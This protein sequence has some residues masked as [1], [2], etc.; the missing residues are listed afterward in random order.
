MV[1]VSTPW[2]LPLALDEVSGPLFAL[3]QEP[4][5]VGQE[6]PEGKLWAPDAPPCPTSAPT[7]SAQGKRLSTPAKRGGPP[8]PSCSGA[9]GAAVGARWRWTPPSLFSHQSPCTLQTP[10]PA[11]APSPETR[12]IQCWRGPY[13]PVGQP[14]VRET[15][16]AL[17]LDRA[18]LE[19]Q[20]CHFWAG[21]PC[22]SP[23]SSLR[24]FTK[25]MGTIIPYIV[26]G[27]SSDE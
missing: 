16:W 4:V 17:E 24:S 7:V 10:A 19:P 18:G 11:S 1:S 2:S 12:T 8:F 25:E 13:E 9:E 14:R 5:V 23:A 26:M 21:R 15:E 3:K 20:L 27:I 22:R 6:V